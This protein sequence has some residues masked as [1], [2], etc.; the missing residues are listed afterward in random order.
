MK[1][2][3]GDY[4]LR[5]RD[6]RKVGVHEFPVSGCCNRGDEDLA[7][8]GIG[9]D[10]IAT[11]RQIRKCR[12]ARGVGSGWPFLASFAMDGKKLHPDHRLSVLISDRDTDFASHNA[13][14]LTVSEL[15]RAIHPFECEIKAIP[16][17]DV[18]GPRT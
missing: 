13:A 1:M 9:S 8:F 5:F 11:V 14:L 15:P 2:K 12:E 18:L 10:A 7:F 4:W 17:L 16:D 3:V 6:R